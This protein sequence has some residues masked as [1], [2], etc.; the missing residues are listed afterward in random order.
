MTSL[1]TN[2]RAHGAARWGWR[3]AAALVLTACNS[4][5][6]LDVNTPDQIT[7][8]AAASPAG[9]AA[10]RAAAIGNFANF[11]AGDPSGGSPV[12]MNM[13]SGIFSDEIISSRGGTEHLDQRAQ[14]DNLFPST[15][16]NV[17]GTASTQIIRA[18][19]ALNT[20]A[21]PGATRNTQIGELYAKQGFLFT[22]V[23]EIFCNG[24][25]IANADDANPVTETLSNVDLY[26]RAI[27]EFDSALAVLSP[28]SAGDLAYRYMARVGKARALVDLNKYTQAVAVVGAG[29]DGSASAAIP[30]AFV[31]NVEYGT[32]SIVNTMYDWMV[33]TPNFGAAD[34]EGGNGLDFLSSG[35]PRVKAAKST[36]AGQDGTRIFTSLMYP[37]P[38]SPVP[39]ATGTEARL[40]EAEALLAAGDAAGWLNGLNALRA[41]FS[42]TPALAPLTDPGTKDARVN[43][44]FRERAFWMYMTAHR[45]GDLR[46]LSRQYARA[47]E[48]IWPTGAYF[49]G[50]V[51]GTDVALKPS[52]A[53]QNNGAWKACTDRNP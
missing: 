47:P 31:F 18:I 3:V 52:Q 34:K 38:T 50:G 43:L 12:G 15:S 5:S 8:G 16:W 33:A 29:G 51:Y 30:S 6:L 10:I 35:D 20:Y 40:I 49:K 37:L 11:F 46:R 48:T 19:K 7:P 22:I 45:V 42:G 17:V 13:Y 1:L 28:T 36:V 39:L 21:A 25:P 4:S 2:Q 53:E 23:A 24:V 9:A 14:N 27:A 41:A 26:N 44:M 32:V